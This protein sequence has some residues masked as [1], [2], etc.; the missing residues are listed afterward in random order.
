MSWKSGTDLMLRV[1]EAAQEN[2]PDDEARVTFYVKVID[3]FEEHDWDGSRACLGKDPAFDR[4]CLREY[5]NGL[6]ESLCRLGITQ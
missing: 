2:F 5:M 3:A 1:I 6:K 4:A